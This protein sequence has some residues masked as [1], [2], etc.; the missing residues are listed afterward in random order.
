MKSTE[1]TGFWTNL[2]KTV[3]INRNHNSQL[4]ESLDQKK[5]NDH[6]LVSLAMIGTVLDNHVILQDGD[7][8]SDHFP[9]LMSLNAN[10]QMRFTES[11]SPNPE[12]TLKWDKLSMEQRSRFTSCVHSLVDTL[13][14]L[15]VHHCVNKCRC[16]DSSC[17]D[18]LQLE[19]D[20]LV[21]CLHEADSILP[22]HK[23]G[24]EKD[25]WTQGLSELKSKSIEIHSIWTRN[26]KP[27]QGPIH[28]EHKR[29]RAVYKHALRAA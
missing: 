18:A 4:H 27:R 15:A 7:N 10:M 3:K 11:A 12:P 1:S 14:P 24:I 26:G 9:I 22:R 2:D 21:K 23:P 17:L 8:I 19:Y 5:W 6:F 29:V 25:W 20:S 28:E 16:R 13:P